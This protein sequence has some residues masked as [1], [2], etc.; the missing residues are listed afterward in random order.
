MKD[1]RFP[2]VTISDLTSPARPNAGGAEDWV[3]F[4]APLADGA[5]DPGAALTLIS[6]SGHQ[7][8]LQTRLL[9]AWPDGSVRWLDCQAMVAEPGDYRIEEGS[10]PGD[11]DGPVHPVTVEESGAEVTLGNGLVSVTL[12]SK[13]MSPIKEIRHNGIAVSSPDLPFEARVS[14][15]GRTHSSANAEE[16]AIRVHASGPVRAIAEATGRHAG[17]DGGTALSYRL[18]VEVVAN[19]PLIVVRY[20]MLHTD[21]RVIEHRL[22][23]VRVITRWQSAEPTQ[24]F[25]HQTRHSLKSRPREVKTPDRVDI[26]VGPDHV[27]PYVHNYE[28]LHDDTDYPPFMYKMDDTM[29]YLGMAIESGNSVTLW[30]DDFRE[31]YPTALTGEADALTLHAWP[32]WAGPTEMHQGWSREATLRLVFSEGDAHPGLERIKAIV[33]A[34][35]DRSQA[36]ISPE[37][38][39]GQQCWLM[40]TVLPARD[41]DTHAGASA[42]LTKLCALPVA[43]GMWDCGDTIAPGYTTT[44]SYVGRNARL[45]GMP[46]QR[47]YTGGTSREVKN[48]NMLMNEPVWMNNEY[49]LIVALARECM[50]GGGTPALWD[51]LRLLA[52]HAVEVDFIHY[53]DYPQQHHGSPAHSVRH[54]MASAY[55]SHLWCEGL[56]AYYCLSGDDDVLDVSIKVGDYIVRVFDNLDQY[57]VEWRFTRELGWGLL[58]LAC[59]YDITREP[60]FLDTAKV[61]ADKLLAEPLTDDC[62]HR[63]VRY[64]F[65]YSSIA[66]GI[67][68]LHCVTGEPRL[69]EWLVNAADH[70]L[71][72]VETRGGSISGMALNYFNA[73]Y[74]LTGDAKYVHEIGDPAA[75]LA[76][77]KGEYPWPYTKQTA[78]RYRPYC[79]FWKAAN[80]CLREP[81]AAH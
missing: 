77:A 79:R 81:S 25:L 2:D 54:C 7:L 74:A 16:H 57:G 44:Y 67:E 1:D 10:S 42:Y 11:T 56:L 46:P 64:A 39:A 66:L 45:P 13:G 30:A 63:M 23:D 9:A 47:F 41:R 76:E 73:A 68:M 34:S 28:C 32:E 15:E 43:M 14:A 70:I 80:D 6:P 31:L 53:S 61:L 62:L 35:R 71:R 58:Y 65:G 37:W 4:S 55:P 60:R 18:R 75:L 48:A 69:A 33:D 22:D 3:R 5:L 20:W 78:Q 17:T 38:Y 40:D 72:Y 21:P 19:L 12:T 26:R 27:K 50:R 36:Q 51:K 8:P 59:V 24:R 29:P 49:D 52:R